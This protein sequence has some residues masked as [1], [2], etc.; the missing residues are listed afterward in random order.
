MNN[1]TKISEIT[2]QGVADYLRI[3]ELTADEENT[4][5]TLIG[6]SK[7]YISSYTGRTAE[8]LDLYQDFVDVALVLIQDMYD[9]RTLYVNSGNLNHVVETILGMH[10]VNLLPKEETE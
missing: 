2:A 10:A 1:I 6:V 4:L 7:A 9:N 5:N 3:P 8:E